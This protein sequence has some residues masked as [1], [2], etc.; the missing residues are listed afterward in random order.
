MRLEGRIVEM[1]AGEDVPKLINAADDARDISALSRLRF[2]GNASGI[3]EVVKAEE[4]A[5]GAIIDEITSILVSVPGATELMT[6]TPVKV[7][8]MLEDSSGPRPPDR[9]IAE[10]AVATADVDT[11]GFDR[12]LDNGPDHGEDTMDRET[13]AGAAGNGAPG[14]GKVPVRV[15]VQSEGTTTTGVE[16]PR[17]ETTAGVEAVPAVPVGIESGFV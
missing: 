5:V 6:E 3:P 15:E 7:F 10:A 2:A 17:I 16:P 14:D 11:G 8:E 1:T 12:R 13:G 4:A 9:E